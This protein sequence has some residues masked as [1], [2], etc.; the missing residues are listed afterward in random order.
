MSEGKLT[1]AHLDYANWVLD[2]IRDQYIENVIVK[3]KL[4]GE[5]MENGKFNEEKASSQAAALV[6]SRLKRGF[7]PPNRAKA[8]ELLAEG[9]FSKALSNTFL[10]SSDIDSFYVE[11]ESI[12]EMMSRDVSRY[13]MIQNRYNRYISEMPA[14]SIGADDSVLP[15]LGIE[16]DHISGDL[17]IIDQE[18]NE[19]TGMDVELMVN[20]FMHSSLRVNA[21]NQNSVPV[22]H[23]ARAVLNLIENQ[24]GRDQANTMKLLDDWSRRQLFAVSG[25]QE[26]A[27]IAG[28][29]GIQTLANSSISAT[30]Y[31]AMF[32]NP[33]VALASAAMN[34]FSGLSTAVTNGLVGD[35]FFGAKDLSK[36]VGVCFTPEGNKKMRALMIEHFVFEMNERD[37]SNP[38]IHGSAAQKR[39]VSS[40]SVNVL[41]RMTD[42]TARGV[43]MAAQMMKDGSWDAYSLDKDGNVVYDETKDRRFY[44][45]G[46][47]TESGAVL[48]KKI[49][50]VLIE[51]GIHTAKQADSDKLVVGYTLKQG[52]K[53]K[54]ISDKWVMGSMDSEQQAVLY[55]F[56]LGRV[57][58]QFRRYLP[59]KIVNWYSRT[60]QVEDLGDFS[61]TQGPNGEK[62]AKWQALEVKSVFG[63]VREL[64]NLFSVH[65]TKS[66]AELQE[67]PAS[68]KRALYKG[69]IDLTLFGFIWAVSVAVKNALGDDDDDRKKTKISKINERYMMILDSLGWDQVGGSPAALVKMYAG[70]SGASVAPSVTWVWRLMNTVK[71]PSKIDKV[72][73][74]SQV[75]DLVEASFEDESTQ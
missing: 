33:W 41:N 70:S 38:S 22:Y 10:R 18:R 35:G 16:S 12:D 29:V 23:S 40:Y 9:R 72:L 20:Q 57:L 32:L 46:K 15:Y 50:E 19:L 42:Y 47:L 48:K 31:A 68:T 5:F 65:G 2:V 24:T 45:D 39:L 27:A 49:R 61:I 1:Q 75:V 69:A 25:I 59:D 21:H 60:T 63:A 56:T 55:S 36:A 3:M 6:D 62:I 54:A 30:T 7:I 26:R 37:V 4:D 13:G 66:L 14:N 43:V 73:P 44:A 28:K 17:Y 52:R 64:I 58:G 67:L 53:F 34:S 71:D 8:S 74:G 11:S 51:E